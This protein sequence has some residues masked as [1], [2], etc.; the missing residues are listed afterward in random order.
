MMEPLRTVVGRYP[1]GVWLALLGLVLLLTAWLGQAYS[2][3][4]WE[5]ASASKM[6]APVRE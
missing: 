2:L 4:D 1:V 5:N 6:P 3:F